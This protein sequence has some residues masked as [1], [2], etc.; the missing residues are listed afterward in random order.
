MAKRSSTA[1]RSWRVPQ[2]AEQMQV[3]RTLLAEKSLR[4]ASCRR[5]GAAVRV[6]LGILPTMLARCG[7]NGDITQAKRRE[8][9]KP[10]IDISNDASELDQL[11]GDL[12]VAVQKL[13]QAEARSTTLAAAAE[14]QA[15]LANRGEL[16]RSTDVPPRCPSHEWT[17]QRLFLANSGRR[18]EATLREPYLV[19]ATQNAGLEQLLTELGQ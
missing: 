8:P 6:Q 11:Q 4:E 5:I 15:H 18:S 12:A 10:D 14:R 2:L 19:S 1:A 3:E 7:Q 9:P 16:L 17:Y 13:E